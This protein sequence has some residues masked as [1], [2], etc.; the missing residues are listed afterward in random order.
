MEQTG[1]HPTE[2]LVLCESHYHQ[3]LS[4]SKTTFNNCAI[5]NR[6]SYSGFLLHAAS[7]G[8]AANATAS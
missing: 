1:N 4:S 6:D 2:S 3:E 8:H 5:Q 7:S